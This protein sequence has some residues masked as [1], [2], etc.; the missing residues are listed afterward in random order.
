MLTFEQTN[1]P[2]EA[3]PLRVIYEIVYAILATKIIFKSNNK[4]TINEEKS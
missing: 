1:V 4:I 2:G 3:D